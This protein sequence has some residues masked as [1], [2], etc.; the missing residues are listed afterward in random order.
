MKKL[1]A[2]ALAEN[3]I[4]KWAR[5]LPEYLWLSAHYT[6]EIITPVMDGLYIWPHAPG[7]IAKMKAR[8]LPM[9]Y[10]A[11]SSYTKNLL[12]TCTNEIPKRFQEYHI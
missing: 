8:P 10:A 2:Q 11:K 4:R 5:L 6:G 3:D 9:T 1:Y 7:A 12:D